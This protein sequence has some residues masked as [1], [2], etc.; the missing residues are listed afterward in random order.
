MEIAIELESEIELELESE[1]ELAKNAW[2]TR[3][4]ENKGIALVMFCNCQSVEAH[5]FHSLQ[6]QVDL[7][8]APQ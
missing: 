7:S 5:A 8:N 4:R 3:G 1:I 2:K 6:L